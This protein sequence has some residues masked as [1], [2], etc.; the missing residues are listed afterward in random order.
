MNIL[1]ILSVTCLAV[2]IV[3]IFISS[4]IRNEMYFRI[5]KIENN[6][7]LTDFDSMNAV[8][9]RVFEIFKDSM[10]SQ[11]KLHEEII[12]DVTKKV[13]EYIATRQIDTGEELRLTYTEKGNWR[14]ADKERNHEL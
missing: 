1:L 8:H 7:S 13:N 5:E 3:S 12:E 11:L 2:G 14:I 10:N 6:K 4:S 9:Y